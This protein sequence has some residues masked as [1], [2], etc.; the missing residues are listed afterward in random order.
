MP[1]KTDAKAKKRVI[2][3]KLSDPDKSLRQIANEAWIGKTAVDNVLKE[4][5]WIVKTAE[6]KANNMIKVIDDILDSVSNITH[7]HMKQ[8]EAQSILETKDVK[9]LNDIGE[10]NFKR[11]QILTGKPTE[12]VQSLQLTGKETPKQLEEIRKSLL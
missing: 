7:K 5:P 4:I 10:I 9:A 3:I 11:K 12:I 1:K 6:D 8:M 2:Q